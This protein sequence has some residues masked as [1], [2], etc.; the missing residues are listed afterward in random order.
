[1][2][3]DGANSRMGLLRQSSKMEFFFLLAPKTKTLL[4]HDWDF[5]G[6]GAMIVCLGGK[7][8]ETCVC[9]WMFSFVWKTSFMAY[10][11]ME[12][13]LDAFF[14]LHMHPNK[15]K[16]RIRKRSNVIWWNTKHFYFHTLPLYTGGLVFVFQKEWFTSHC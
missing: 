12:I 15:I 7:E 11:R 14:F 2:S 3:L 6:S 16:E 8:G 13:I 5:S 4:T 1:M 10:E 9:E